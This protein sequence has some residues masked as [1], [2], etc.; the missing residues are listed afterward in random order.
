VADEARNAPRT[1]VFGERTLYDN[2]WVK[3]VQLDIQPPD[4]RR[5]WYHVV[6]LS[7][8]AIA[9][10]IDDQARVLMLR[11]HRF[12][13]DSFGW[14]LPGGIVDAGEDAAA[15]AARET[16]EETGWRPI[17]QMRH[18]LTFQPMPGMVDTPHGLYVTDGAEQ[19]GD[20][21]DLEEAGTVEW[22]PLA[23]VPELIR[24]GE[25]V[26]AG[27]LVALLHLLALGR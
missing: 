1:R 7:R 21:T 12:V 2:K 17:G 19:I 10:V 18:L 9:A 13:T 27:S 15:A 3:L 5:W 20:P 24:K 14:E 22:I 16:E 23:D 11:R 4:G 6:R 26:G 8:V 25:V